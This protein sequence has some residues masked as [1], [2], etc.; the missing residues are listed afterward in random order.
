M[1]FKIILGSIAVILSATSLMCTANDGIENSRKFNFYAG[2]QLNSDSFDAGLSESSE[3]I[4]LTFELTNTLPFQWLVESDNYYLADLVINHESDA[5]QFDSKRNKRS[6]EYSLGYKRPFK[7][8]ESGAFV[9]ITAGYEYSEN[10]QQTEE[11]EKMLHAGLTLDRFSPW[12]SNVTNWGGT[13]ALACNEE[14]KDDE[15]PRI[16][17]GIERDEL[18]R[19]GCGYYIQLR[20]ETIT[21]SGFIWSVSM[22]NYKG[23]YGEQHYRRFRIEAVVRWE[24]GHNNNCDASYSMISRKSEQDFLGFDDDFYQLGVGCSHL[25]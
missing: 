2:L 1:Q 8:T 24:L 22:D 19:R 11:F 3:F 5:E 23:D 20:A 15:R 18:N 25:F 10:V 6:H 4:S 17:F 13:G 7:Q 16:L 21:P 9:G 14:E 12:S